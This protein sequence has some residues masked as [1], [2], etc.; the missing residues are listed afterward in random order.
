L[1]ACGGGSATAPAGQTATT[2]SGAATTSATAP[3]TTA[4]PG[5]TAS[6]ATRT[7]TGG[8]VAT[9]TRSAATPA[10]ATRAA[11]GTPAAIAT[12]GTSTAT[13]TSAGALRF[14][15]TQDT[16]KATYTVQET[17]VGR[18]LA[19]AVGSTSA[20]TGEITIDR[21][22]PSRSQIGTITVDISKLTSDSSQ[23]DNRIRGQ[24][25]ESSQ[26]PNATFTP[27]R[28]EGLPTTAYT[29]GQELTFKIVGDLT[30]R[31]VTKE[32]TFD[33]KGKIG[34]DTFSGTATTGFKMT[35][36]GFDPPSIAGVLSSENA[37]ALALTIEAKRAP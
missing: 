22:N 5:G 18:G 6:A 24:W 1:A 26:Y 12:R 13:A 19:T 17:F 32:V 10:T 29:E 23:R 15:I 9:V 34:G 8:A 30:I 20:I 27:K 37:V 35:D 7:T 14:V 11:S 2:A 28:L 4:A 36:F 21:Q 31:N 16:S 3:A 33:A 25:L